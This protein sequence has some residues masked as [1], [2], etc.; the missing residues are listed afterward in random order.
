[1]TLIYKSLWR[2]TENGNWQVEDV[3]EREVTRE[4]FEVMKENLETIGGTFSQKYNE[5]FIMHTDRLH[6][7]RITIKKEVGA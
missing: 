5:F 2:S 7:T 1:M 4:Q 3:R 6:A